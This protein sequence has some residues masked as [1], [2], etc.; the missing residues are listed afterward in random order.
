MKVI[1]IDIDG[2]ALAYP[3]K[4]NELFDD[5][6]NFIVLYSARPEYLRKQTIKELKN[7]NIYYHSLVLGKIRADV[8]ID[9][10]NAGGINWNI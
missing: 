5:K 7:L 4:V 1:S 6:N 10:K 2:T 3:Q 9:D 8:Y